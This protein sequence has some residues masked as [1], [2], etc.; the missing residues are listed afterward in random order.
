VFA[1]RSAIGL[2]S[3]GG[4]TRPDPFPRKIIGAAQ[5]KYGLSDR[6]T[7]ETTLSADRLIRGALE[8]TNDILPVFNNQSGLDGQTLSFGLYSRPKDRFGLRLGGALS[9]SRDATV[10][11]LSRTG[12]GRALSLD[13]DW[14]YKKFASIGNFYYFSPEFYNTGS[15][16]NNKAGGNLPFTG[17]YKKNFFRLN[18]STYITNLDKKSRNG[19]NERSGF[20][21]NHNYRPNNKI[22]IQNNV[23][24]RKFENDFSESNSASYRTFALLNIN[25]RVS[26]TAAAIATNRKNIRPTLQTDFQGQ[27]TLGGILFLDKRRHNQLSQSFSIDLDNNFTSYTQFRWRYK[28]WIFQPSFSWQTGANGSRNFRLANGIFWQ[29]F[30]SS[31]LSFEYAI[32]SS[33][34]AGSLYDPYGA[35]IVGSKNK[36]VSHSIALNI[37]TVLGFID[38][39]PHV[40]SSLQSG[41]IKA[42]VFWMQMVMVNINQENNYSDKPK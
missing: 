17:A 15:S 10:A 19:L 38:N 42:Q 16:S 21:F 33:E 34:F 37:Q 7:L 1:S 30:N 4:N 14:R 27:A 26:L 36:S 40:L 5:Y 31:R 32:T 6:L 9:N 2:G 41:Y 35:I 28:N 12:I 3:E 25:K 20:A 23:V 39:K 29:G 18:A 13:Y 22:Q 11:Q 8:P 24:Y